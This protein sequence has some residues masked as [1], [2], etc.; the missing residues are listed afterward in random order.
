[1][2]DFVMAIDGGTESLRAA[3]FDLQGNMVGDFA[4]PYQTTF[5][6]ANYAEQSPDDWWQATGIACK[7][8]LK[9]TNTD[10]SQIKA[11]CIDTTCCTVVLSKKNGQAVRPCLLWMDVR[12][13]EQ[14]D[15][16]ANCGDDALRVNSNG[17][18]PVSA[19]WMIPKA[20]WLKQ[21]APKDFDEAEVVC[22]YQDW[23][24]YKLTGKWCASI[25]NVSVRWHYSSG[26][27]GMPTSLMDKVGIPELAELWPQQIVACGEVIDEL[28]ADAAKH[29][30]LNA[31]T[32]VVQGGADAFIG[33]IGLGVVNPGDVA[34]ITGSSHLQLMVV[35]NEFHGQ[36]VW[37]TYQDAVYPN[38]H[39]LEG[40]QTSTGSVINWFMRNFVA[41]TNYDELNA[42]AAKLPPGCDGLLSQDHFQGNRTPHTNP[43]SVGALVGLS[44]AH[45]RAHVYR[46]IIEGVCMGTKLVI[47]GFSQAMQPSKIVIAGGATN[48]DLWLQ[49]HAD[50]LGIELQRTKVAAAPLLGC[51]ILGATGTGYFDS[52]EKGCE[53]MVLSSSE[54]AVKPN[55]DATKAYAEIFPKYCDLYE[56]LL[57][58]SAKISN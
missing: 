44:L 41:D 28:T 42:E 35:G 27:G 52:I 5:P 2:A 43:H 48:S 16:V 6:Q 58:Y 17:A 26:H 32:P 3:I 22:E 4:S 9:Q 36:G 51:A 53:A 21:N 7:E 33:M 10:A 23:L 54:G 37:G 34:L 19:E 24:N 20:L 31:G 13:S 49:I 47:D 46:A 18:G 57:P 56:S 55:T 12:A 38:K 29:T 8:V 11:L 1:M 15:A 40:G 45:T 14:A 39:I 50:T 30:G 25:N